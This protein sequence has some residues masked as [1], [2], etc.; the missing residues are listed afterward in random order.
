MVLLVHFVDLLIDI[1]SIP[2][3]WM[4]LVSLME[5]QESISGLLLLPL[6]DEAG[7]YP[8][9]NCNNN[10]A[11]RASTPTTITSV[12]QGVQDDFNLFSMALWD[13]AG[14]GPL[15]TCCTL[16]NPPWFYKE[17]PEP[18]TNDIEMRV[19]K[20]QQS[21]N[22]DIAIE[23]NDYILCAIANFCSFI[24]SAPIIDYPTSLTVSLFFFPGI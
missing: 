23:N 14:C 10:Q 19:C 15:N 20:D 21:A 12:I 7:T 24:E 9:K 8:L 16:N 2:T 22:E 13:G 6:H 5:D 3:M 17:L 4:V 1:V 11:S 18:T